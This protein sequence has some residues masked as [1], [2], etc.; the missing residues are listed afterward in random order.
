MRRRI[1]RLSGPGVPADRP[2]GHHQALEPWWERSWPA[3]SHHAGGSRQ[4]HLHYPQAGGTQPGHTV[5]HVSPTHLWQSCEIYWNLA[6]N[7]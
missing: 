2:R 7:G 6:T 1:G 3:D 4:A 5:H